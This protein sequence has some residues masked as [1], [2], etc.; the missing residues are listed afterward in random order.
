[1]HAEQTPILMVGIGNV[2]MQD[3]GAGSRVREEPARRKALPKDDDL[4]YGGTAG[5]DLLSYLM[6]RKKRIIVDTLK[7]DRCSG[8]LYRYT[9]EDLIA[10]PHGLLLREVWISEVMQT[11][12]ML[13]ENPDI[14][15]VGI[16]PED[17]ATAADCIFGII[18]E[19][20]RDR[21]LSFHAQSKCKELCV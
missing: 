9:P 11:L 19:M 8:T 6:N 12:R 18:N 20:G 3:E 2:L 21:T 17:I 1:M 14:E 4:L 5:F 16:V 15:I 7:I 10:K 13:G